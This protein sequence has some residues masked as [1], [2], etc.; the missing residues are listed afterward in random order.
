MAINAYTGDKYKLLITPDYI[1]DTLAEVQSDLATYVNS[2]V[3]ILDENNSIFHVYEER[4]VPVI[5][6][7]Y[8]YDNYDIVSD[9]L[10]LESAENISSYMAVAVDNTGKAVKASADN[11]DHSQVIL[12]LARQSVLT[13]EMLKIV[14]EGPVI[15]NSWSWTPGLP[16]Y[17]GLAGALTQSRDIGLFQIQLGVAISATKIELEMKD[18]IIF[19]T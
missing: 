17:L 10:V 3:Q 8:D 6:L 7:A 2:Y 5:E 18:S 1:A 12:G 15:N 11:F 16:I 9:V 4:G 14:Q 13:G 19:A